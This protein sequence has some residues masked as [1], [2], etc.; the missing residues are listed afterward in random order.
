MD[1][2]RPPNVILNQAIW[3]MIS[4]AG[5]F[6]AG[7]ATNK[8][9]PTEDYKDALFLLVY[10]LRY[11]CAKY[12]MLMK[13][14]MGETAWAELL[15]I[16]ESE[17]AQLDETYGKLINAVNKSISDGGEKFED[18]LDDLLEKSDKSTGGGNSNLN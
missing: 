5:K 14:L 13:N 16:T 7:L 18:V 2:K 12:E 10:H 9:F 4:A 3:D 8:A 11:E 15:A 1:T 6:V 17:K